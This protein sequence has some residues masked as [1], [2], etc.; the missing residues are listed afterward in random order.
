MHQSKHGV[1]FVRTP[2]DRF[3]DLPDFDYPPRYVDVDGLRMA[4]IDVGPTDAPPVL[5]L[6]GEPAWSFLYR[7]MIPLL[8]PASS[9][10]AMQHATQEFKDQCEAPPIGWNL[11]PRAGAMRGCPFLWR[12]GLPSRRLCPK[13]RSDPT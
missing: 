4:Y 1:S 11:P 12:C 3:S 10:R 5:L 7:R 2:E 9:H 13:S 6:H 8:V